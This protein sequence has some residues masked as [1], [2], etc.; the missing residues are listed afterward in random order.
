MELVTQA[1]SLVRQAGLQPARWVADKMSAKAGQTRS[2]SYGSQSPEHVER[3]VGQHDAF[4]E[5][6]STAYE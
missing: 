4:P 3:G 2:L 1:C 6:R 5:F